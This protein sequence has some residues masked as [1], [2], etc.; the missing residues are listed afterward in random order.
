MLKENV[1]VNFKCQKKIAE[2]LE[3]SEV[4]LC[5]ILKRKQPCSKVLAMAITFMN[6]SKSINKFFEKIR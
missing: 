5:R 2:Y 3:I 6:G 4:T 1:E